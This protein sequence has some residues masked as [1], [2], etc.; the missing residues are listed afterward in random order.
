[1]KQTMF[2]ALL[3]CLLLF[4]QTRLNAQIEPAFLPKAYR[5]ENNASLTQFEVKTSI[6]EVKSMIETL[7]NSGSYI[8]ADHVKTEEGYLISLRIEDQTGPEYVAKLMMLLGVTHYTWN[9]ERKEIAQLE[10]DLLQQ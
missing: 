2:T 7:E 6:D 10:A 3:A 4:G 5:I 1:M 8:H 9:N